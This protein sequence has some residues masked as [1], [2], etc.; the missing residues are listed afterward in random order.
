MLAYDS[1]GL[2]LGINIGITKRKDK[3]PLKLT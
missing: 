1:I 3:E 2:L